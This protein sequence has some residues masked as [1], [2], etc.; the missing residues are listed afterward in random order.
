MTITRTTCGFRAR[1]ASTLI[2]MLGLVGGCSA[3]RPEA[4][5]TVSAKLVPSCGA[6]WGYSAVNSG[7][8]DLRRVE[9]DM[10]RRFDF[11][12]RFHDINDGVPDS[13]ERSLAESGTILHLA[14]DPRDHANKQAGI[15]WS[16]VASGRYDQTLRQQAAGVAA[17]RTPVFLTFDHEVDQPAKAASGTAADFV[18]A[19]R[20]VH[21]LFLA[22]GASNAVWVWVV[23]GW[24]ETFARAGELWPGNDVVDW[25]SWDVYNAAGCRAGMVDL[26]KRQTFAEGLLPFFRWLH[27]NGTRYGIDTRKPLMI[28]EAGSIQADPTGSARW[29]E[30]I[31]AV[32]REHPQIKAVTLWSGVGN[33]VC[34][35]VFTNDATLSSAVRRAGLDP[36]VNALP[37]DARPRSGP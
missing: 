9:Q 25:I 21:D 34:D 12:Y 16:D 29:Y 36:W 28:S 26:G 32:L 24:E 23:L 10:G 20:H 37:D 11:V 4:S 6:L 8:A 7:P 5:C 27:T 31:P 33:G 17:L 15:T 18:A 19:W 22:A 30:E 35:Y 2:L 13:E 14:L 3:A 1:S